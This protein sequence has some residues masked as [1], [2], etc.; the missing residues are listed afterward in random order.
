MR[1]ERIV[2]SLV[3]LAALTVVGSLVLLGL[4]KGLPPELIALASTIA[5]GI[6]GWLS[7]GS[8]DDARRVIDAAPDVTDD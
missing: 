4:G 3:G 7:R 1:H 5:G 6:L 8:I 2:L